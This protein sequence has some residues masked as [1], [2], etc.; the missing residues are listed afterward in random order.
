MCGGAYAHL[1][2]MIGSHVKGGG[3]VCGPNV[4]GSCVGPMWRGSKLGLIQR[5][6]VMWTGSMWSRGRMLH[7]AD[8]SQG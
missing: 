7:E 4:E 2:L 3:V 5:E 6:N 1:W 8:A